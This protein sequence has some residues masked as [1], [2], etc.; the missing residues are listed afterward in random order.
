MTRIV[1]IDEDGTP[2][3]SEEGVCGIAN[4]ET[5]EVIVCSWIRSSRHDDGICV[6][7]ATVSSGDVMM[8]D[9]TA[10]VIRT[11]IESRVAWLIL[12]L[13]AMSSVVIVEICGSSIDEVM[14][15][16]S[17][18]TAILKLFDGDFLKLKNSVSFPPLVLHGHNSEVSHKDSKKFIDGLLKPESGFSEDA[19]RRN[20]IRSAIES[21]FPTKE[22]ICDESTVGSALSSEALMTRIN[23]TPL[24]RLDCLKLSSRILCKC[25]ASFITDRVG[26]S[27]VVDAGIKLQLA[28][29]YL[30]DFEQETYETFIKKCEQDSHSSLPLSLQALLV[31]RAKAISIHAKQV[32]TW[33][34]TAV[35]SRKRLQ[36]K[37]SEDIFKHE[38][39]MRTTFTAQCRKVLKDIYNSHKPYPDDTEAKTS[40][41]GEL[42]LGDGANAYT[43]FLSLKS[44]IEKTVT[45]YMSLSTSQI[46]R[47]AVQPCEFD[48]STALSIREV[49]FEEELNILKSKILHGFLMGHLQEALKTGTEWV[50]S[51]DTLQ[52]E[53]SRKKES[54]KYNFAQ[55]KTEDAELDMAIAQGQRVS[56]ETY[57]SLTSSLSTARSSQA[58][59]IEEKQ[60]DIESLVGAVERA[61]RLNEREKAEMTDELMEIQQRIQVAQAKALDLRQ[62]REEQTNALQTNL[63]EKER[64]GHKWFRETYAKQHSLL[65]EELAL[66]RLL[67]QR[68]NEQM[69]ELFALEG[70]HLRNVEMLRVEAQREMQELREQNFK[71]RDILSKDHDATVSVL[72]MRNIEL[73]GQ[74]M[75]ATDGKSV[76]SGSEKCAIM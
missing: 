16:F 46:L 47:N 24:I 67:N 10:A 44:S 3:L 6:H 58:Q 27:A 22:F 23:H 57:R 45:S 7:T 72:R 34:N 4:L 11:S 28:E 37:I 21:L 8:L 69:S 59:K 18:L 30:L 17:F 35:R 54:L 25:L 14:E 33:N 43:R 56:A 65:A 38:G 32:A 39:K 42:A 64:E 73:E 9:L 75:S 60:S 12:N 66:E 41:S 48:G 53:T 40:D 61:S 2:K 52:A 50:N 20:V 31:Y 51:F 13:I 26:T 62:Q 36:N 71:K 76:R 74:L 5:D 68:K 49:V 55:L 70:E 29:R 63:L 15:Q 1:S 19:L